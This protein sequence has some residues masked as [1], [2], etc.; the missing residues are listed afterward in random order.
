MTFILTYDKIAFKSN[1]L[2]Q[3]KK[4]LI[5]CANRMLGY[6]GKK[7]KKKKVNETKKVKLRMHQTKR[8]PLMTLENV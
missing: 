2:S 8:S 5:I 4:I 6:K 3:L 7:K 1:F